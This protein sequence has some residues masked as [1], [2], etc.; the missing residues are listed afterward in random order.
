[1]EPIRHTGFKIFCGIYMVTSMWFNSIQL[2]QNI[3][4]LHYLEII[5]T[6]QQKLLHSFSEV[7]KGI[8]SK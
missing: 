2:N 5:Q 1:M 4:T 8:K 7:H 3:S 6:Q